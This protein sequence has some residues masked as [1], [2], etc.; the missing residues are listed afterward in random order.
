MGD[1]FEENGL[2]AAAANGAVQGL[3]AHVDLST[4][5]DIPQFETLRKGLQADYTKKTQELADQRKQLDHALQQAH[6]S[7]QQANQTMAVMQQNAAQAQGQAPVAPL[8]Q[9][10]AEELEAQSG[11]ELDAGTR[12]LLNLLESRFGGPSAEMNER[13]DTLTQQ[14]SQMSNAVGQSQNLMQAVAQRPEIDAVTARYGREKLAPHMNKIA[15]MIKANP[16]MQFENAVAAVNPA[17][18]AETAR[19]E[20]MAGLQQKADLE[21]QQ[22]SA[23]MGGLYGI[24]SEPAGE[25][26][27]AKPFNPNESFQ[28]SAREIMGD[29]MFRGFIQNEALKTAGLPSMAPQAPAV[30]GMN[31]GDV[32]GAF[33]ALE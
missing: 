31:P 1:S 9:S 23:A 13:L 10:I 17:L 2:K 29:G 28:D 21:N 7:Q 20:A 8:P 11:A 33:P 6:L 14:V 24:E 15:E 22:L 18:V 27:G 4:P 26:N 19:N 32:S 16:G 30:P 5:L 3:P 25:A 12:N